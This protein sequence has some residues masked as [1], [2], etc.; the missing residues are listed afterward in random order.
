MVGTFW[1][2]ITEN[3][4]SPKNISENA[5]SIMKRAI[6]LFQKKNLITYIRIIL[7]IFTKNIHNNR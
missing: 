5:I 4:T 6:Q 1:A 7:F 3:I 2:V